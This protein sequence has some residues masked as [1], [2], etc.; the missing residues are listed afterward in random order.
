M[1]RELRESREAT[2][3]EH[4]R[5]ENA[6]DFERCIA[7][8]SHARYEVMPTGEVW[9]G[10]TQVHTFLDENKAGFPDFRF[11]PETMHHG[12]T[13]VIVEGRFTGTQTGKWR[14]LPPTGRKV[15]FPMIIVFTF[16]D[17]RMVCERT[18]FDLGTA[19]KQLGV[20]RD[21]NS[22]A[23]RVRTVINHPVVVGKALIRSLF[24]K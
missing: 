2:V 18:Y 19:L 24:H 13:A 12:D 6:H 9:D 5:A 15:E 14:G 3:L 11:H 20:A 4:M 16:E 10:G 7:A 8:F 22:T 17:D 23:G 21:P 1:T